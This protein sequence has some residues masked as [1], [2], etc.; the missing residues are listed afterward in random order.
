MKKSK[1][2]TESVPWADP[3]NR[4]LRNPFRCQVKTSTDEGKCI[5]RRFFDDQME[6]YQFAKGAKEDKPELQFVISVYAKEG[7]FVPALEFTL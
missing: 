2:E 4:K 6:A 5:D 1:D 7:E 3:K